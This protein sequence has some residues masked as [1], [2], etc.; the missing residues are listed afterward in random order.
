[1]D[2]ASHHIPSGY[3][4]VTKGDFAF[5][6]DSPPFA[7]LLI[8]LPLLAMDLDLPDE[9]AFWARDDR[10]EFAEDFLY[11][12][13][14]EKAVRI[15]FFARLPIV[16]LGVLGGV[17]MFFWVRRRYGQVT[18]LVAAFFYFL[19]PNILAHARLATTDMAA[20]VL[21]MCA[22]FSFWDFLTRSDMRAAAITGV[23][24]GLAAMAKYSALLIFPVFFIIVAGTLV[25]DSIHTG[26]LPGKER[27]F[28]V[29]VS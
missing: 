14:R 7:R 17:F 8:A 23:F 5:A 11:G 12:L 13:N 2:E 19:S 16:L 25:K 4:Y 29:Y 24:A 22:V 21:I 26:R 1:M 27:C 10:A 3:V 18:A 15:L 6:T 9:R 20:T 28:S